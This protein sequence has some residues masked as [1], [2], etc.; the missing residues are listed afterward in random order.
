MQSSLP[1]RASGA[2]LRVLIADG[3]PDTAWT[4]A[5]VLRRLGEDVRHACDGLTALQLAGEFRP[6]AVLMD[7]VLPGLDSAEVARR[8]RHE[9]GL[10]GA[11]LVAVTGFHDEAHRRL[12]REAGFDLY[13][14]K[15]VSLDALH[16]LLHSIR[17]R[18]AGGV[19]LSEGIRSCSF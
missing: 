7:L 19:D 4:L 10:D 11:L 5:T 16:A 17:S 12:A 18:R 13:L 2:P 3:Y 6:E 1:E 14:L 9:V 15:P 8:L